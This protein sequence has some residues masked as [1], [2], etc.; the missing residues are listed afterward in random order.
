MT[1]GILCNVEQAQALKLTTPPPGGKGYQRLMRGAAAVAAEPTL[2]WT[3]PKLQCGGP[4]R[5][6]GR[7]R[8]GAGSGHGHAVIG[9][10]NVC[11]RAS[12]VMLRYRRRAT[13]RRS[14][15]RGGGRVTQIATPLQHLSI[16]KRSGHIGGEP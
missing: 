16:A 6:L 7:K 15:S 9:N 12:G 11:S 8:Q 13:G 10:M 4:V 2:S 3:C 1:C 5:C 14:A